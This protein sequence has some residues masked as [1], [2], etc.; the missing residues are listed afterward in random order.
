M[1]V[2]RGPQLGRASSDPD[3]ATR[4]VEDNLRPFLDRGLAV[5]ILVFQPSDPGDTGLGTLFHKICARTGAPTQLIAHTDARDTFQTIGISDFVFTDRLHG[6]IVSH[7]CGIPFRLSRHHQKCIDLLADLGHPD[8]LAD[9]SYATDHADDAI[10][11]VAD[12]SAGQDATV[13]RHA[14]L[15]ETGIATW[16]DHLRDRV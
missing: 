1:P 9:R 10:A 11:R 7:I 4:W 16:L 12:W 5:N 15:A 13:R 2:N 6:A 3:F 8:A 14:H